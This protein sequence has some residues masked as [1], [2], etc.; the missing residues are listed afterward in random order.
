MAITREK[1]ESIVAKL[2][3][4]LASAATIAFVNFKG[5]TVAEANELRRALRKEGVGYTVAKKTLIERSL[6]ESSVAGTMP[7]L[8]GET[9]VAFGADALAPARE[10]AVF[11]K[12]FPEHLAFT[13]GVFEGRFV[14]KEEI[15]AIAA[16]PP[17]ETLRAQFVH[18]INSPLTKLAVVLSEAAKKRAA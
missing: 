5:L 15:V 18:V 14:S 11:I 1:K 13:G 4:S 8:P 17:I 2:R 12:K 7:V 9:A 6:E 3:D 16:I 10:L